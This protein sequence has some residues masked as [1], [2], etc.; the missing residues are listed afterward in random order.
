MAAYLVEKKAGS[1]AGQTAEKKVDLRDDSKAGSRVDHLVEKMAGMTA[2]HLARMRAE[3]RADRWVVPKVGLRAVQTA[4]RMAHCLE[5]M[6]AKWM[7]YP[8]A[9]R[10]RRILQGTHPCSPHFRQRSKN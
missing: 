2:G 4:F 8:K 3:K 10:R 7:A 1:M 9:E 6:K 5:K